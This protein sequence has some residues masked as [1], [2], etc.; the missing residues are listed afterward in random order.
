MPIIET[1]ITQLCV[2]E[3]FRN[4]DVL[5]KIQAQIN[6]PNFIPMTLTVFE[7]NMKNGKKNDGGHFVYPALLLWSRKHDIIIFLQLMI[8]SNNFQC[9]FHLIKR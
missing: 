6:L 8:F 5:I 3:N 7:I 1:R 4:L 9:F 2:I